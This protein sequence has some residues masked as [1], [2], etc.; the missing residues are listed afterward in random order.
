MTSS[1]KC[2]DLHVHLGRSRDGASLSLPELKRVADRF[3][4]RRAVVFPIDEANPGPSYERMNDRIL[5]AVAGDRR[6]IGFCRLNPRAGGRAVAE[7]RRAGRAGLRGVKLHP[8]SER[9][10]AAQAEDLIAEIERE[11][12]P[13]IL[14]TSH[15]IH[16]RP[17]E[18]ERIFK[19]HR[20]IPFVLAHA[21]K[22]AFEEAVAAARGNRH[23]WIET[24]TVSYR[25]TGQ[26]LAA[27]GPS[28]VVFGSDLPYSHPAVEQQ[29]FEL[30]LK[31]SDRKKV[32]WEN[33]RK[34][35]GE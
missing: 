16:C 7:L 27:L 9:F 6:L 19:R 23:V 4:L 25:R 12:F 20:R 35:L 15:E 30:L 32:Y 29:K 31:A 26:I 22:D 10:S 18:W 24:S 14:H 28:Q 21:G 17:S 1:G 3:H 11:R 8:R 5:S 34:I 2:I 33:A 13:I